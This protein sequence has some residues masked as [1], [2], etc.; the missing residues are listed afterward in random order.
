MAWVTI[1]PTATDPD[2]PLTSFLAKA[3]SNN[4]AAIAHGDAGAPRVQDA[5]LSGTVTAAG[6]NWVQQRLASAA[7]D[8]I[9]QTIMARY[10]GPGT[11]T[12]ETVVPGSS[13][14]PASA[15]GSAAARSLPGN[16]SCQG[17]ALS[18]G[19]LADLTT[20]WRRV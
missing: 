14:I 15:N 7:S 1:P 8:G 16:W 2:A 5:A 10:T 12:F 6:R 3:W 19:S 18:G 11:V 9:G 17:Y 20:S 13:L 4:P